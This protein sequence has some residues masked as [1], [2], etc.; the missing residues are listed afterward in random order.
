MV[1]SSAIFAIIG[2]LAL[3]KGGLVANQIA[4]DRVLDPLGLSRIGQRAGS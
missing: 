2:A 4:R 1:Y 3:E